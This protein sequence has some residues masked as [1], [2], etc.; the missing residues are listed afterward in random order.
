VAQASVNQVYQVTFNGLL[1]NQRTMT[2]FYYKLLDIG[3]GGGTH[4]DASDNL[5]ASISVAADLQSKYRACCPTNWT[6]DT[7]WIQL[8]LPVRIRKVVY[9]KN[10]AGTGANSSTVTNVSG[11]ITRAGEGAARNQVGGIR[12]PISPADCAAGL[13][14]TTPYGNLN[15]LA[16]QMKVLY[17][18]AADWWWKPGFISKVL[19]Q[20]GNPTIKAFTDIYAAFAQETS[21]VVRRRTVGLGI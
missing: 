16:A 6:L 15:A 10:L 9:A 18:A 1:H 19:D 12:V 7:V 13:I 3:A 8:I 20:D 2:T 5:N 17:G 4:Q 14:T 21:R 11:S